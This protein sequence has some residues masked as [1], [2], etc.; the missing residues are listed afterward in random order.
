MAIVFSNIS[1]LLDEVI[2]FYCMSD[3]IHNEGIEFPGGMKDSKR[4]FPTVAFTVCQTWYYPIYSN[5]GIQEDT[6]LI[7]SSA[8]LCSVTWLFKDQEHGVIF[9]IYEEWKGPIHTSC[10]YSDVCK[11]LLYMKIHR[12]FMGIILTNGNYPEWVW[13]K[14]L[15]P[16]FLVMKLLYNVL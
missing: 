5:C 13:K 12:W 10:Q 16:L 1:R 8:Y 7:C 3:Y 4:T 6:G 11:L 2:S 15:L 14:L 9:S